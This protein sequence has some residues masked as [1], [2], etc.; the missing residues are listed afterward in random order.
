MGIG[1]R[2]DFM[3][4]YLYKLYCYR[5]KSIL[6]F[7]IFILF[8]SCD[9]SRVSNKKNTLFSKIPSEKSG[10]DFKNIVIESEN[11][12]YYQYIY[13]YNGGGVAVADFNNDGLEDLFFTSNTTE[14]K[15]YLN[16]G[17]FS[18]EDITKK[19][20]IKKREGF[21]TGISIVDINN[22]GFLDIYINR[23]GWFKED[24]KYANML[25]VNNGNLTFSEK[26]KEYGLDD[27][28]R[29]ITSTFFDCDNDGDLDV[30]ITNSPMVSKKA[31]NILDLKAIQKD[32][33]TL[34]LKGSDKLYKNDGEGHF[35]DA[36]IEAGI[37]PELA[38]G[39][40]A[41]VGDLNND[42]W[43]DIYVNNDF[44]MPDFAYINNQDGTFTDKKDTMF[45]HMSFY[46]MGGDIADINND[47]LYDIISL[48]MSPEDYIRS[49][50]TMAMTS[51]SK[52]QEMVKK[53]YQYQYMHNAL[54]LNNGNETFSEIA[55]MGGVSNTDWSWAPLLADFDLDG[56]NDIYITNGVY[57][58]V[59]D[60]DALNSILQII[61][62]KGKRPTPGEFLKYTKMLPQQKIKN[63]F[64]KNNK[65]LTFSNVSEDWATITPT[66]SNG[67]IYSDLD[68]DGDLDIVVNNINEEATILKNN[69]LEQKKGQFVQFQFLGPTNNRFGLGV[70]VHVYFNDGT[71]Q[72]RQLINSR[73][74][75]SSV[76]N[77][78]HFG[79]KN[80]IGIRNIDIIWLDGKKQ[81][82]YNV[83]PNQLISIAYKDATPK[84]KSDKEVDTVKLFKKTAFT[85]AHKD[86]VFNDY[87]IQLLLPHKLS[88]L[89]PAAAKSD[90]NGDGISDLYLGG[91]YSQSG[92]LLIG[93]PLG[94][95]KEK[96]IPDFKKD[97]KY[98]D[99]GAVFFDLENDGD[100]DLYVVSGSYEFGE[101]SRLFQDRIYVNTGQGEFKKCKD[102]LPEFYTS[103]SVVIPGDY[104]LDG[105][106]DL[107]VGG[108]V[109][110][111]KY[112]YA[113][114][115][116][117]LINKNGKFYIETKTYAPDI[118]YLGMVTDA[119]WND[120]DDDGDL[121]LIVAGEWMGIEVFLNNNGKLSKTEKFTT[122]KDAK[123][124]WNKILIAD[125][126][127]DG[128][129]DIIAGNLGLN[130]KHKASY[131]KPF[132]IYTKDFD[133]DGTQDIFLATYYKDK[134]VPVRGKSCA[135]EQLPLLHG[136]IKSYQD[137]A[138][139][140]LK[141]I[142]GE[143]IET[144]LNLKASEF[145]SGIFLNNKRKGFSFLPFPNEVQKSVINSIL[146]SDFDGD[147]LKDL[148]MA[149]N[150]YQSEI[151]T[152]RS[153]AGIGCFLK[154]KGNGSF[155]L[156]PN[157]YTGFYAVKDVRNMMRL[158]T[159]S[160][161]NIIV[162]NNNDV[163]A[164]YEIKNRR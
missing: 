39:L 141:A 129:K 139:Q 68:N 111:G 37:L 13:S 4:I 108:R 164:I 77:K 47:T 8:L 92:T 86:S 80:E 29:S 87:G 127:A 85:Y 72:T 88:Q 65:D 134:E 156:I 16:K 33:K 135:T 51:I 36:S 106:T 140:D 24:E 122:L 3:D 162:I 48:D 38:F 132:Q 42:G 14:N 159:A 53:G 43:L 84:I 25:Y 56:Y 115:S 71:K 67:A 144:A 83:E 10:V 11:F 107:F 99:V 6:F 142:L 89:G 130:Y 1:I 35:T 34:K 64:F 78:I 124:W 148:L 41:Q 69:S 76:T 45:K 59:M 100:Q 137:F 30:Y 73:G 125:I 15:L 93:Q 26:A 145:R 66:F 97:N 103:G 21:D 40:N 46:S 160:G 112:P 91:G 31:K 163:H 128:D 121:D 70:K 17:G 120:L 118:E 75:L 110:P 20:G 126:D 57:R 150:N 154:G 119:K 63:Y 90:L 60:K 109:I 62:E 117:L 81:E 131:K 151:E 116:Y 96:V 50:T 157:E 32:S 5:F 155:N 74:Y 153:D 22:D 105:D 98:E 158:N 61:R 123:G 23:A 7:T 147:G 102:C 146:F 101:N 55:N 149:G 104:D 95:Y 143:G 18:F 113:P 9:N 27:K 44:K 136:K 28:G 52:F 94:K 161:D 152:T 58:D 82:L 12:H 54:Q 138:N 2:R 19:S 133:Y 114:K 79:F 49:K